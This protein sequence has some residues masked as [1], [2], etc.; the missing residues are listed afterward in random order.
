ML[1]FLVLLLLVVAFW[2]LLDWLYRKGA[3][4]LGIDP[5]RKGPRDARPT[6]PGEAEPLVRCAA[7]GSYVP[8]SRALT[9]DRRED[10]HACSEICRHRLRNGTA[11]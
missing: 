9:L 6:P 2:M 11:P 8:A 1:R 5:D 4:A 3:R 10:R 7:C